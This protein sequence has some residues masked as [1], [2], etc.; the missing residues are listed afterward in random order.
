VG[1][2]ESCG[3]AERAGGT[4]MV[5][6]WAPLRRQHAGSRESG[7]WVRAN[8]GAMQGALKSR[9]SRS[10]RARLTGLIVQA[11]V[12]GRGDLPGFIGRRRESGGWERLKNRLNFFFGVWGARSR[13]RSRIFGMATPPNP[14]HELAG[15]FVL[16]NENGTTTPSHTKDQLDDLYYNISDMFLHAIATTNPATL[17]APDLCSLGLE[18]GGKKLYRFRWFDGLDLGGKRCGFGANLHS[19]DGIGGMWLISHPKLSE[20]DTPQLHP[21][22]RPVIPNK[23]AWNGYLIGLVRDGVFDEVMTRREE[24]KDKGK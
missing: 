6:R 24:A 5:Q 18:R 22:K 11:G 7:P 14:I 1:M 16:I 21:F 23:A 19:S 8:R 3:E 13:A 12:K 4:C 17:P 15:A 2:G 20:R 10:A 9:S